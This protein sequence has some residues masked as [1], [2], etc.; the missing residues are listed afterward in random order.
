MTA[1]NIQPIPMAR[2]DH[3]GGKKARLSV[4]W[5]TAND[6][7]RPPEDRRQRRYNAAGPQPSIE[8]ALGPSKAP[9]QLAVS[10]APAF[11]P[12]VAAA[13]STE[14]RPV[15]AWTAQSACQERGLP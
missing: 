6:D 1:T 7:I 3:H 4:R 14:K 12:P 8:T 13:D 11:C 9:R 2:T 5:L 10:S 15:A